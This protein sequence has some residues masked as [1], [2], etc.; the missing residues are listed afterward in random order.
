MP[1]PPDNPPDAAPPPEPE[2]APPPKHA[3]EVLAG[4]ALL[5]R[6][7]ELIER[8]VAA[9]QD[10]LDGLEAAAEDRPQPPAPGALRFDDLDDRVARLE[11]LRARDAGPEGAG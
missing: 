9:W 7:F 10:R 3:P 2:D 4:L 6:R 1:E 5:Q 11:R 8:R